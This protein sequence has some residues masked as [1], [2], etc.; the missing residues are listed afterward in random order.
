MTAF[1]RCYR[2][3]PVWYFDE[4]ETDRATTDS[5]TMNDDSDS[6]DEL[7]GRP[8]LLASLLFVRGERWVGGE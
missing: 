5:I 3:P 2:P 6:E 4:G 8:I 7:V 1:V